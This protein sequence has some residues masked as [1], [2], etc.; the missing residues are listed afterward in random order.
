MTSQAEEK[1]IVTI[2][3]NVK[4]ELNEMKKLGM[5]VPAKL[6]KSID[7]KEAEVNE[8]REGGM[9]ISEIADLLID[10]TF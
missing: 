4:L 3:E 7:S 9:S 8:Y 10:L 5:R 2:L 1:N 6:L